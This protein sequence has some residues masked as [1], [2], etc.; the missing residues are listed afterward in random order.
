MKRDLIWGTLFLGFAGLMTWLLVRYE[1]FP[2]AAVIQ[3]VPPELVW[4]RV[5][6]YESSS[7]LEL[8]LKEEPIGSFNVQVR[9]AQ[10]SSLQGRLH[11]AVPVLSQTQSVRGE[12]EVRFNRKREVSMARA[13]GSFNDVQFKLRSDSQ[14]GGTV[15]VNGGGYQFKQEFS[16]VEV[17][18]DSVSQQWPSEAARLLG[19]SGIPGIGAAGALPF[20]A[21]SLKWNACTV[22]LDRK[23]VPLEAYRVEARSSHELWGRIWFSPTGELLKFETSLGFHGYNPDFIGMEPISSTT[24]P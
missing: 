4:A 24:K 17:G 10:I 11:A 13:D 15:E 19:G 18:Q 7:H 21:D 8:F 22:R 20:S 9:P 6:K 23:G 12:F 1:T 2:E 5:L 3:R 16:A 14:T